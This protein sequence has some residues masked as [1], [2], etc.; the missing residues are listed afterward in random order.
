MFTEGEA[1]HRGTVKVGAVDDDGGPREG[2]PPVGAVAI[3]AASAAGATAIPATAAAADD[4]VA[5]DDDPLLP[6][7]EA[8]PGDPLCVRRVAGGPGFVRRMMDLGLRAGAPLR[9]MQKTPAGV[10]VRLGGTRMAISPA[11]GRHI[12]VT[13]CPVRRDRDPSPSAR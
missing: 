1:L 5:D 9:V 13:R 7:A 6:L 10:I 3:G 4:G 8:R 11:A 12:L 2:I